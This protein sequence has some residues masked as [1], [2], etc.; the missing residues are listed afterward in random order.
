MYRAIKMQSK[1]YAIE[2][3]EIGDD[4]ENIEAFL[5]SGDVVLLAERL[6][7]IADLLEVEESEI[8]IVE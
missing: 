5:E 3:D 2:I 4:Q 8:E 7:S 6:D 1:T